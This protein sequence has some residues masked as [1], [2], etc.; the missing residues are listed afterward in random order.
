M[1]LIFGQCREELFFARVVALCFGFSKQL[2]EIAVLLNS[3]GNIIFPRFMGI[4]GVMYAG[5]IADTAAVII[6]IT[7]AIKEHRK[8]TEMS[9]LIMTESR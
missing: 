2:S 3:T 8:M 6:A 9:K 4:D 5:P 1:R 7:F